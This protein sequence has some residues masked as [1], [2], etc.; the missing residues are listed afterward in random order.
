L[1]DKSVDMLVSCV[2]SMVLRD[3]S[4]LLSTGKLYIQTLVPCVFIIW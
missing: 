3:I 1:G 4:S 2:Y